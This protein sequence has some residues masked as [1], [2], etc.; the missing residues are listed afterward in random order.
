LT[1]D[2]KYKSVLEKTGTPPAFPG[3]TNFPT[4]LSRYPTISS[5]TVNFDKDGKTKN[6]LVINFAPN[7]ERFLEIYPDVKAKL[8]NLKLN[9]VDASGGDIELPITARAQ[10]LVVEKAALEN[11]VSRL[12]P[13]AGKTLQFSKFQLNAN[14]LDNKNLKV[15]GTL[16]VVRAKS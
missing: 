11:L 8:N 6:E 13:E 4:E 15:S 5:A 1:S 12:A 3:F 16:T 9:I 14:G 2:S 7:K 10:S